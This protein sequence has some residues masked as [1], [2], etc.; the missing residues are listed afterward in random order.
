MG[1]STSYEVM[2]P[3]GS[4]N[5]TPQTL[6]PGLSTLEGKTICEL[7]NRDFQGDVTFPKIRELLHKKY[8]NVKIISYDEIMTP[9]F[10]TM[11][12]SQEDASA[13]KALGAALLTKGCHGVISGNGN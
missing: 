12:Q 8:R 13:L 11:G 4:S 7:W 5:L 6:A 10:N 3:S 2:A 9:G 1:T